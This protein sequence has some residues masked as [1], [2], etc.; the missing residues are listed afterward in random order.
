[1]AHTG[2]KIRSSG[3][4]KEAEH[5][6]ARVEKFGN[7]WNVEALLELIPDIR[8]QA[9]AIDAAQAMCP[10]KWMWRSSKQVTCGLA[11]VDELCRSGIMHVWPEVGNRETRC[12]GYT[13]TGHQSS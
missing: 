11:N 8:S 2:L 1:M 9:I 3:P 6:F 10:F 5:A 12:N 4:H 7:L 13:N